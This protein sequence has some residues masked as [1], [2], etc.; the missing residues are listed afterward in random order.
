[1]TVL[2]EVKASIRCARDVRGMPSMVNDVTFR[3]FS[4]CTMGWLSGA[5]GWRNVTRTAPLGIMSTSCFPTAALKMGCLTFRITSAPENSRST[6]ASIRAPAFSYS[7][8]AMKMPSPAPAWT[9]T[10][11]PFACSFW[12]VSGMAATRFSACRISFGTTTLMTFAPFPIRGRP[13]GGPGG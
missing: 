11:K 4:L 5:A 7:A 3:S 10:S 12:T 13:G 2:I 1:M 6:S 9:T 8:S